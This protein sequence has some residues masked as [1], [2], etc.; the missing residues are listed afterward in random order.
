MT[1]WIN[2]DLIA[3]PLERIEITGFV[4]TKEHV[5]RSII[6]LERGDEIDDGTVEH[7]RTALEK[8]GLFSDIVIEVLEDSHNRS[9]VLAVRLTEKWTLIPIPFFATDGTSTRGGLFLLESNFLGYGKFLM[10]AAYGGIDGINGLLIY[11]DPSIARSRWT[12]SVVGNLGVDDVAIRLP[13]GQ[14]VRSYTSNFRQ[15]TVKLGYLLSKRSLVESRLRWRMWEIDDFIGGI[16]GTI[17]HSGMYIEPELMF[18]FD[19]TSYIGP[20]SVGTFASIT[21]RYN[22]DGHGW[23]GSGTI[24]HGMPVAKLHRARILFNAG[25]GQMAILGERQISAQ[26]GFR[27]LPYKNVTAD[28][29]V[30]TALY[31]DLP[32]FGGSWGSLVLSHYWEAG[33]YGTEILES[34]HFYGTGLALRL[35]MR[36]IA[37]PA[38]G[39]DLAYN[40]ADPSWVFSFTI[41]MEM[42]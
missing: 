3:F 33:T 20:L 6:P 16:D 42:Q 31:Y 4:R 26:D 29:W 22:T 25:Y 36:K 1:C 38:M 19:D 15:V 23:E 17:L 11:S 34:Q 2:T 7:V 40:M 24:S 37:V 13:D 41:G 5:I 12:G 8:S 9:S 32:V 39:I 10:G 30:G 28:K 14:L 21:A 35:F 27:T 18:S